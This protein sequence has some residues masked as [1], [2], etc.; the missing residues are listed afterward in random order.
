M[1]ECQKSRLGL[2]FNFSYFFNRKLPTV[3]GIFCLVFFFLVL[4]FPPMLISSTPVGHLD[5][6][7]TLPVLEKLSLDCFHSADLTPRSPAAHL[8]TPGTFQKRLYFFFKWYLYVQEGDDSF[9]PAVNKVLPV[10]LSDSDGWILWS[11]AG[12]LPSPT[13]SIHSPS[14][15]PTESSVSQETTLQL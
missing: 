5:N 12:L 10:P 15:A 3:L 8:S 7:L 2:F 11:A 6:Q 4:F 13:M 9:D 14:S 1:H